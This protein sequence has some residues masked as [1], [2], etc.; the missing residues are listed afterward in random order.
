[1]NVYNAKVVGSVCFT[2]KKTGK[3][4]V[5]L[6]VVFPDPNVNG[7]R[8]GQLLL[9]DEECP[10]EWRDPGFSGI[11]VCYFGSNLQVINNLANIM[12]KK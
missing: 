4:Y 6:F 2:A 5:S 9:S 3:Q 12:S 7:D 8:A 10:S 1:M 11:P